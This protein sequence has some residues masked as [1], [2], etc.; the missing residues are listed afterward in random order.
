MTSWSNILC[1]R[2]GSPPPK[3]Q[4]L[5]AESSARNDVRS[6]DLDGPAH[7]FTTFHLSSAKKCHKLFVSKVF[8]YK[9]WTYTRSRLKSRPKSYRSSGSKVKQWLTAEPKRKCTRDLS[10]LFGCKQTHML[11]V[12]RHVC[13]LARFAVRIPTARNAHYRLH[14]STRIIT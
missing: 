9:I 5:M 4:Q 6:R 1:D 7:F 2:F 13:L 11:I 10:Q 8:R 12:D 3:Q 14:K